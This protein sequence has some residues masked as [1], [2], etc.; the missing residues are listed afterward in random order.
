M[1]LKMFEAGTADYYILKQIIIYLIHNI[2]LEKYTNPRAI[3]K[4][5]KEL[6]DL[7]KNLSKRKAKRCFM[8]VYI[9]CHPF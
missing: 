3:K 1:P 7:S 6:A 4:E 2:D 8:L 9:I 5:Y